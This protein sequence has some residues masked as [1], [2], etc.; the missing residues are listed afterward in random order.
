M[1]S[2]ASLRIFRILPLLACLAFLAGS[3]DDEGAPDPPA[4]LVATAGN[5]QVQ[6][7]WA[8]VQGADS[9]NLYWGTEEGVTPATGTQIPAAVSPHDHTGLSNGTTYFYVVTA[10]NGDGESSRS[11]E[12]EATPLPS[13]PGT[14]GEVSATAGDGQITIAWSAASRAAGYNVYWSTSAGVSRSSGTRIATE[15]T[16]LIHSSLS[17]GTVYYYVVTAKNLSGEG[18]ES[19]QVSGTPLGLVPKFVYTANNG[20]DDISG[21]NINP[22]DGVLSAMAGSIGAG[23]QPRGLALNPDGTFLFVANGTSQSISVFAIDGTTGVLTEVT[24]SPFDVSPLSNT[25]SLTVDPG[26]NF[27]YVTHSTSDKISAY[28]IDEASGV[29]TSIGAALATGTTPTGIVVDPG[30]AFVWVSN[31]GDATISGFAIDGATGALTATTPATSLG[32]A[33]MEGMAADPA[34]DF[35]YAASNS[36]G[37]VL[38]F[39]PDGATGELTQ[40]TGSPFNAATGTQDVAV[41]PS[42]GFVV[43]ANMAGNSVT[44]L[45]VDPASGDLTEVAGSPVTVAAPRSL[46]FDPT[47]QFLYVASVGANTVSAFTFDPADGVLTPTSPPT[48]MTGTTP[49]AIVVVGK[50]E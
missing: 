2:F 47:G 8:S 1:I 22:A 38:V 5:S 19:A 39:S 13:A 17:K 7:R 9:Y 48:F 6:L 37:Q 35:I 50:L 45:Q 33:G 15:S 11:I 30:G 34:G 31:S 43:A 25:Q 44:V 40:V 32:L 27:L 3:C 18:A 24:G 29:L 49:W 36:L 12:A 42:G 46:A 23:T 20:S 28:A 10:V 16:S 4:S 26:G 21:Y 14:P 41:H